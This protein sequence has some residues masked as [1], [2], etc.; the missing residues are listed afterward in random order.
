MNKPERD[1]LRG[2]YHATK[3][4]SEHN[5][6]VAQADIGKLLD[7]L[8]E[9]EQENGV[10]DECNQNLAAKLDEAKRRIAE[11]EQEIER[12][13]RGIQTATTARIA[14]AAADQYEHRAKA[15]ERKLADAE[16][17]HSRDLDAC[18]ESWKYENA[19]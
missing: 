1:E 19:R 9:A 12:L 5:W 7:A 11:A 6:T 16:Q 10:L 2:R 8:D 17:A 15:A 13:S 3:V 18:L 14:W 4:M